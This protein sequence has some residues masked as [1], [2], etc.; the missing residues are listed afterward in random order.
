M[1]YVMTMVLALWIGTPVSAAVGPD[2]VVAQ[3][4]DEQK[5]KA[6]E[7]LHEKDALHIR[8]ESDDGEHD[9][10]LKRVE[11]LTRLGVPAGSY[12]TYTFINSPENI[13]SRLIALGIEKDTARRW[14]AALK[15]HVSPFK[16]I[17]VEVSAGGAV[18]AAWEVIA[19]EGSNLDGSVEEIRT[20]K[21]GTTFVVAAQKKSWSRT[22]WMLAIVVGVAAMAIFFLLQKRRVLASTETSAEK[23]PTD[24]SS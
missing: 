5:R 19:A 10:V 2:M 6:L 4:S 11:G 9:A 18:L 12:S 22:G 3:T 24:R 23:R 13:D 7:L 14:A 8:I 15:K 20:T 16:P 21:T 17:L 1:L